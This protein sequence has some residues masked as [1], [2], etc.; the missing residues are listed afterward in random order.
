MIIPTKCTIKVTITIIT[1]VFI[2]LIF[3]SWTCVLGH[4]VFENLD[5]LFC[6][7]LG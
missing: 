6:I 3:L 1:F 2:Y 7:G 5:D 4:S